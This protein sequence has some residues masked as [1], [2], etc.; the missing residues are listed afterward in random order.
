MIKILDKKTDL[1]NNFYSV[2][3]TGRNYDTVDEVKFT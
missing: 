1:Y 3:G 2:F